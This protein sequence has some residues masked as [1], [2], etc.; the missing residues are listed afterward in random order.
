MCLRVCRPPAAALGSVWIWPITAG[1]KGPQV[2]NQQF[3]GWGPLA[4]VSQSEQSPAVSWL[5]TLLHLTDEDKDGFHGNRWTLC[6]GHK[7]TTGN[8]LTSLLLA[9]VSSRTQTHAH[10]HTHTQTNTLT[11]GSTWCWTSFS[12]PQLAGLLLALAQLVDFEPI[13]YI[14][15]TN[16]VNS[17][18]CLQCWADW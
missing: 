7:T 6:F 14:S 1:L 13:S 2:W 8:M 11:S 10:I 4:A 9:T 17:A 15:W 12:L 5:W 18:C 16:T 3:I